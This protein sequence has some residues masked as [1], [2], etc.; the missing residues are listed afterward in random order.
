MRILS[1]LGYKVHTVSC[2]KEAVEYM[3]IHRVDLLVLDM[4]MPPGI[5]GL[6]TYR[7]I[8]G[9]RPG[10]KAIITSGYSETD[11]VSEAQRLGA[12]AYLRK[13]YTLENLGSAVK[14]E[15]QRT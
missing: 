5:D 3:K 7:N 15:L 9:H 8:V 12:G 13:P 14:A 4:I 11:R 2:G 10:Q 1:K 6:E